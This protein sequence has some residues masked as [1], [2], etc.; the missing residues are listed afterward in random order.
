ME[1]VSP[2][3]EELWNEAVWS[4][5]LFLSDYT[6]SQPPGLAPAFKNDKAGHEI[7]AQWRQEIG[8]EDRE[9]QIRVL[10]VRGI[11]KKEPHSYR[12]VIGANP[13]PPSP[14]G[15]TKLVFS[16]SRVN[17]MVP[18]T[19][20]NLDR[21]LRGYHKVGAFYLLQGVLHDGPVGAL[22]VWDNCI[23]KK[24]LV[25]KEA[26]QIG[27]N[28]P[29]RVALQPDDDPIIPAHQPTAPV[30]ELLEA[31]GD[32]SVNRTERASMSASHELSPRERAEQRKATRRRKKR[33]NKNK[34]S[35]DN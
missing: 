22:P 29:D 16:M 17:T 20:E 2:I 4:A 32:S 10:I 1:L 21:F 27:A 19:S 25:V 11:S 18:Q 26:W 3:R 35:P 12:V 5:T 7:F 15:D 8:E 31:K 24:E 23:L 34:R 13:R 33:A 9:N 28:D 14:G 30:L 6:D